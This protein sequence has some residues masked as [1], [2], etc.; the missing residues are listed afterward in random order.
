M[1]FNF[2]SR[3][4]KKR[5]KQIKEDSKVKEKLEISKEKRKEHEKLILG[6]ILRKK[7]SINLNNK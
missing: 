5:D 7:N 6:Y 2:L 4:F 3:E 1:K